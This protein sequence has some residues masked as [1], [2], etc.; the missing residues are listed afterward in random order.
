MASPDP[1][2]SEGLADTTST[3]PVN[4][5]NPLASHAQPA[6]NTPASSTP[7]EMSNLGRHATGNPPESTTASEPQAREGQLSAPLQQDPTSVQQTSPEKPQPIQQGLSMPPSQEIDPAPAPAPP[8]KREQ[9]AP[10]IGPSSDK[11]T[12]LPKEAESAGVLMITLLLT[13]GARHPYKIDDKYLK[14]RNVNVD[15][16]NPI[17]L[18]IYD[19]KNLIWRE[20]REGEGR[21]IL[22][23]EKVADLCVHR[24]MGSQT[25]QPNINTIDICRTHARGQFEIRRSVLPASSGLICV[26]TNCKPADRLQIFTWSYPTCRTH[27]RQTPRL[28]R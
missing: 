3:N 18:S 16:N 19:L 20:W 26:S 21:Y 4:V 7:L 5:P 11:P 8:L 1:G 15:G 13:N 25:H 10:A 27:D 17:N 14:K 2:P 6:E 12:P 28:Y 24:R 23:K 22:W 9:T